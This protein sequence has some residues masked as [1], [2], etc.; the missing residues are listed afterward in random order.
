MS[1]VTPILV[2]PATQGT[3]TRGRFATLQDG[4]LRRV[5]EFVWRLFDLGTEFEA[6]D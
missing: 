1:M 5:R 2:L 4:L 6:L 3:A